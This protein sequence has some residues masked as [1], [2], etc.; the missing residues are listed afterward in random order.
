MVTEKVTGLG[1][2]SPPLA[3]ETGL[4]TGQGSMHRRTE[5]ENSTLVQGGNWGHHLS[6]DRAPLLPAG[7]VGQLGTLSLHPRLLTL[8]PS[9]SAIHGP[10]TSS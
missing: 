6:W 4:N 7:G 9:L 1:R 8:H 10:L 3:V 2:T 5:R